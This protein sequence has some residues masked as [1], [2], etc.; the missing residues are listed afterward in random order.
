MRSILLGTG[1]AQNWLNVIGNSTSGNIARP[2]C[3][4]AA[5]TTFCQCST[6]FLALA[7]SSFTTLR[8]VLIGMILFTPSSTAFCMAISM[9]SPAEMPSSK[10]IF[11]GDSLSTFALDLTVTKTAFFCK[12]LIVHKKSTPL[13]SNNVKSSSTRKRNTRVACAAALSLNCA[14]APICRCSAL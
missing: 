13:P 6:R 5:I 4:H 3:S 1:C 7:S 14:V 10:V 9:R 11:S 12:S 2:D 8:S